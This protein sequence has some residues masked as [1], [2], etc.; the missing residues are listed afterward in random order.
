MD[1]IFYQ[2]AF[3]LFYKEDTMLLNNQKSKLKIPRHKKLYYGLYAF[4][5]I[6]IVLLSAVL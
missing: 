3:Y 1:V 4:A 6:S 5:T 2:I